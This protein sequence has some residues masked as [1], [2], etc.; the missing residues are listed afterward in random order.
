MLLE[1]N[2]SDIEA[3]QLILNKHY[4]G[5]ISIIANNRESFTDALENFQPQTILSNHTLSF[6]TASEALQVSKMQFPFTPFILVTDK[7]S[8]EYAV[9]IIKSGADDY[10]LKDN[11]NRLPAAIKAALQHSEADKE[12]K[13]A[14]Q[15]LKESEARFRHS[16]DHLLEGVQIVSFDWKYI[17]VNEAL[18]KHGRYLKE[19]LLGY[20]V[21]EKYPGI[22]DTEIFKLY[23]RCMN[24][25]I[26]IQLENE[27]IFPDKTTGWFELS[28]Q[29][30]PEGVFVMSVDISERKKAVEK[31]TQSEN[32]F[33]GLV[34]NN[35]GIIS[36]I[37]EKLNTIFRSSSAYRIT[38]WTNEE[39][40]RL[41]PDEFIHP[42][43]IENMVKV[44]QQAAAAPGKPQPVSLRVKHKDGHY[45][46]LEGVLNNLVHEPA[47]NG[48]VSNLRDV[49]ERKMAEEKLR[50]ERDKFA[51]IAA[52]SPGLIYSMRRN[53]DGTLCYPYASNALDD[54]YGVDFKEIEKDAGKIFENIHPGDADTVMRKL[55][56]TKLKLV[57]LKGEYRYLHPRKG[58]VWHEVNSLPVVEPE[59]TVI[60]H[61]IVTDITE[62]KRAEKNLDEERDKF[63]KIS[64]T[65]PGLIYSFRLSGDGTFSFP[66]ASKAIEE[67][68]GFQHEEVEKDAAAIFKLC[69]PDDLD[70]INTSIVTSAT[71]NSPWKEEYR[72]LHP[73][74][75]EIFLSGSSMPIQG[76]DGTVIWHGIMN[77]ITDQKVAEKKV[78][79]VN[80]LYSFISQIN[81]MIVRT[82]DETIL[83]KEACHIAVECGKFKKARIK[84]IDPETNQIR[85]VMEAGEGSDFFDNNKTSEIND[86]ASETGPTAL[87]IREA[88]NII[89][90]DFEKDALMAPWK[91][92]AIGLGYFSSMAIPIKK[93]GKTIGAFTFY[94]GEKNFF[95]TEEI[96][97]LEETT[98]DVS[99]ALEIFEKEALRKHSELAVLESEKRYQ[100]LTEVSPVGIF[101]T[102]VNGST[103]YVNP[104]WCQISGLSFQEALGNDWL[105]AVHEDDR[106][107]IMAG[108]EK[109]ALMHETSFSEYRFVRP[110]GTI[111]WVLGQAI[112]EKN[113]ANQ[114][115]GYV[116]TITDI[117]SHKI[118]EEKLLAQRVQ[119]ETLGD[120]LSGVMLF[121]AVREP[122][123]QMAFT[124]FSNAIT[125]L[126]GKNP[127][128]II[129]DPTILY[130]LIE[131]EDKP[132]LI[133]AAEESYQ[134][135]T[136]IN[137]E[138]RCQTYLGEIRWLN[139]V[140]APRKL[141]DGSVL[142]DGFHLDITERRQ[143]END[144]RKSEEKYRILVENA[145]DALFVFDAEKRLF[146]DLSESA[147]KLFKFSR[148][149]LLQKSPLDISPMYQSNG[150]LSSEAIKDDI[151]KT[152]NGENPTFEWL[153]CD[154][155][156]NPIP[157]EV[158]LIRLPSKDKILIRGSV[159]D[160]T[161][162][163][164]AEEKL[165]ENNAF[166][167]SI[168]NASPDFIYIYDISEQK[169]V[170]KND[171]I[172]AILG[173]SKEDVEKMGNRIFTLLMHPEDHD[174]Y[175]QVTEPK[176]WLA[177]DKEVMVS[178]YRV[179][180]KNGN[181]HWFNARDAVF[182]RT[183]D[184]SPKHIF[185]V[186]SDITD[187][188]QIESEL[189]KNK[190]SLE[191][192]E[193]LA[194]LGSWD[195]GIT[196]TPG[197]WSKQ[198]FR[199]FGFAPAATPPA[200]EEFLERVHPED[201]SK[202]V[203]GF[204]R[205][206]QNIEPDI[207]IIR[208]NPE[209]LPL[210]Y[211]EPSYHIIRDKEGNLLK[212][213]GTMLD[214]TERILYEKKLVE[215]EE[216]Y[217]T[218]IDQASDGIFI[219]EPNG[220]FN[221]V[222]DSACK[223]SGYSAEELND[224]T[225]YNLVHPESL[226][227]DP[228][229]F[230]EMH[231]PQGA[232]SERKMIRKDK[233]E[234]D[235]EISAK[236]LSDK[237]F[238]AFI[239]DISLRKKAEETIK[240]TN[241]RYNLVARATND[242]IW[243]LN[244]ITGEI[245][246]SGDSFKNLFG[247]DP[248]PENHD[249]LH[250]T[251]LIHPDDLLRVQHSQE[252][253][254]VNPLEV[255]WE[256]EYRFKKLDGD[257]A[258][259]YD[260]GYIIRDNAGNA[261][262]MIGATQ[263]ITRMKEN[264]I[265]LSKLNK[266]LQIQSEKL[267]ESNTELEQ[268]A[269]VASHDLQEPLRMVT[270][271]LK[272]L[273]KKYGDNIDASGKRYIHFAVDGANRMR[274]IILDLLEYSRVGRINGTREELNLNKLVKEITILFRKQ[275]EEKKA[276]IEVGELPIIHAHETPLRQVFQNLISNALKYS[277]ADIPT[278]IKVTATTFE[279]HWQ[280][281]IADNGIGI[282][283]E[284][285]EKIF[286]IFQ[287]LHSKEAY[288][289]T[290]IGLAVTKKI[291]EN[292]GGKIWITSEEG[293]GSTFHFT[294]KR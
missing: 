265:N 96:A 55:M 159:T 242:S 16:F 241:E 26:S 236:F 166:I 244:L 180:D 12:K 8:E 249:N 121:Q 264:E 139:I 120:N 213:S 25:R 262:R 49:T 278:Q 113:A 58:E 252:L 287:R 250:W 85:T 169:Y 165:R 122:G 123:G 59:G 222:N 15:L 224:L 71:Y 23:E 21:M 70:R 149:E 144:L 39:H 261:I 40:A 228:F 284:Y 211:L 217:R 62:R 69:H 50:N 192:S 32:R 65:V 117:S 267:A 234:L 194:K 89:C 56:E 245:T 160:I 106:K 73:V 7:V 172:Q 130:K 110:D 273:E 93:F 221:I 281:A 11:L 208:T 253:V 279:D 53:P 184:G 17:Y 290:G 4:R 185:T 112:P 162:R 80:R 157:C 129:N 14:T 196:R 42:D 216:K 79:K 255:Y 90:N 74:K 197:T 207:A 91:D 289:G 182:A 275:I 51:K 81:Q 214:I 98:D 109:A 218:L 210:R 190:E 82:S 67:M 13:Q 19:E 77:D 206:E 119:L 43:N 108:W 263:D 99:F 135:L 142:W 57:P 118:A 164:K 220:K 140:S 128:E 277:R 127:E 27:F 28:F 107:A 257:Y 199:H 204:E 294:I 148:E 102:D 137:I 46:C 29:P 198:M 193:E 235:I 36:L 94:A 132:A 243:D 48:I 238:I 116:G 254:L 176:Y 177:K 239:R 10:V 270:S 240:L 260:R 133:A 226:V 52:T 111:A 151:R 24:E 259:V 125:G 232:R 203:A 188:K 191:L 268:F 209:L 64:A 72:Y 170:Y 248:A 63:A 103:T 266:N 18:T 179:K 124:Y 154:N 104:F 6:I 219:A 66:Y 189:R 227:T 155:E 293:K 202:F 9:A 163:K 31:L 145:P 171:G 5:F 131:D 200:F 269:F 75:G 101:H 272:L 174:Y 86:T 291:I 143:T 147:V 41:R 288:S 92:S 158:R 274:Q 68:F 237:R 223:M 246:R 45:I 3:I 175:V 61:G 258:N 178:E 136:T 282:S 187:S 181:W 114:I 95:D 78:M 97:L 183:A 276:I 247:Y 256:Q 225:I 34:E 30:V 35:E 100:T 173:Y 292:M 229:R 233:S 83:F 212:Y 168:N 84:M 152:M 38:G 22:E 201:R 44:C 231:Q 271:F 33:R 60:C 20:T 37:D 76:A 150:L 2:L 87:A 146:V 283:K 54:I 161:E 126:T 153:H 138:V 280:F 286:I 156:G 195:L 205:M 141:N 105:K 230:E 47:I 134:T 115:V 251:K 1:E 186:I 215:S 167:E 88:R 285:F